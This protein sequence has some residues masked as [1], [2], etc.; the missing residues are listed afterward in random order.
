M[1][2]SDGGDS[3]SSDGADSE[4][5]VRG[6]DALNTSILNGSGSSGGSDN[7]NLRRSADEDDDHSSDILRR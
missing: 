4:F 2:L 7:I 5:E 1:G 3:Q 6:A